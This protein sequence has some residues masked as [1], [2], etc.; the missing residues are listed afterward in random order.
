MKAHDDAVWGGQGVF[1]FGG[2]AELL[3]VLWIEAQEMVPVPVPP[4]SFSR[5]QRVVCVCE[6]RERVPARIEMHL[7]FFAQMFD[8]TDVCLR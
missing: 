8:Q 5:L 4:N 7:C 2:S 6:D 3:S 1:L